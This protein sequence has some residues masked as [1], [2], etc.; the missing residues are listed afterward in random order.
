MDACSAP[1]MSYTT[2]YQIQASRHRT[3]RRLVAGVAIVVEAVLLILAFLLRPA[4]IQA[5]LAIV[6]LDCRSCLVAVA[7]TTHAAAFLSL[8]CGGAVV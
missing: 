5:S 8:L 2:E 7:L 4:L 1:W 3:Y 6:V